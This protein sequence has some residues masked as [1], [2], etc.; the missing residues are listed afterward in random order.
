MMQANLWS[1]DLGELR[2][3]FEEHSDEISD[4]CFSPQR[5]CIA[6]SSLDKTVKV[7]DVEKV[8]TLFALLELTFLVQVLLHVMCSDMYILY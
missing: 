2:G 6:T 7:W 8:S 1:T 4:A 3:V 5:P